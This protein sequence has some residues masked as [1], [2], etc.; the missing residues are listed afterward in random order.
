[1]LGGKSG[2]E[3]VGAALPL[4][5]AIIVPL[6]PLVAEAGVL[7]VLPLLAILLPLACGRFPGESVLA[8][9]AERRRPPRARR[10]VSGPAPRPAPAVGLLRSRLLIAASLAERAPPASATA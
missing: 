3:V 4:A 10:P 7:A 5:L 1:M 6:I 8:R 9:L 2:R